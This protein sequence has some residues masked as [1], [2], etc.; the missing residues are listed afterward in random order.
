MAPY[1]RPNIPAPDDTPVQAATTI[2]DE[3]VTKFPRGP[4]VYAT[5]IARMTHCYRRSH[6]ISSSLYRRDRGRFSLWLA[7][8]EAW[9][10]RT[11]FSVRA[12]GLTPDTVLSWASLGIMEAEPRR[13]VSLRIIGWIRGDE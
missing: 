12:T 6:K 3:A 2:A 7:V 1:I 4:D 9:W 8:R 5:T 13:T 10:D 11:P